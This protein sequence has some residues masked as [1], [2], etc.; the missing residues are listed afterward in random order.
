MAQ[1]E[2]QREEKKAAA[3]EAAKS[4]AMA[5]GWKGFINLELS[6]AQKTDARRWM[7]DPAR[8]WDNIFTLVF[9]GYKLTL[10]YDATRS[11]YNLSMTCKATDDPNNGY[12]LSGRGGSEI[13]AAVSF[14][15]KHSEVCQG[16]WPLV[17]AASGKGYAADQ[18]D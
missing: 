17:G 7:E 10:S 6:D 5:D 9:A 14:W 3:R 13:A 2:R 11:A 4:R 15:Y 1:V 18:F 12:T 8:V 16:R